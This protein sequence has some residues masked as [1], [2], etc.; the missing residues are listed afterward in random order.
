M[1]CVKIRKGELLGA[2]VFAAS[3]AFSTIG[4]GAQT[5]PAPRQPAWEACA[6]DVQ[7]F[8]KDAQPGGGRIRACLE[9]HRAELSKPCQ[10]HLERLAGFRSRRPGAGAIRACAGDVEKLCKNVQ[11]GGG[12]IVQCL[13]EHESELSS[14]CKAVVAARARRPGTS[15]P[16][17]RAATPPGEKKAPAA[18][19]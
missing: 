3:I 13:R 11:P 6:P 10:E 14:A 12:R 19:P 2:A 17:P 9:G 1:A 7:K 5:P 8:C 18:Q 15:A 4:A 16:A